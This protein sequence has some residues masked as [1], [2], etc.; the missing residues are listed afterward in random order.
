MSFRGPAE[1]S[2]VQHLFRNY[3]EKHYTNPFIPT[4]FDR[5]EF[6]YMLFGQKIMVRHL[7]FKSFEELKKT[8]AKEG[9][10]HVYRSAAIYQ[11]PQ[12]PMEEKGW[13]GAELIFDI[14]ADHLK[15]SCK[16]VHDYYLCVGCG[17][18]LGSK[19][20]K[21]PKCG[22]EDA[23]EIKMVCDECL[24]KTKKEMEKLVDFLVMD[25][26][27]ET[28]AM[29][30]SFSGNRGYHLA[31]CSEQVMELDRAS[32][33]E[34]VEYIT[35]A[36]VELR[37]HG[38]SLISGDKSGP[39]FQD[40]GWGGR[41]ARGCRS[42]LD[43]LSAGGEEVRKELSMHL[44]PKDLSNMAEL[45]RYWRDSPRW[46][47]LKTGRRSPYLETLARLAIEDSASHIDTVVTTDVHRLLRLSDTLNGKTGLKACTV[48]LDDF[49]SFNPLNDSVVF[50]SEQCVEVRVLPT[51]AF[52]IGD[53]RYGPYNNEVVKLPVYVAVYLLC[54]GLAMM[55][56][57]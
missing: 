18:V 21:C 57:R 28:S 55:V 48:K 31:V 34:I 43:R 9:P 45:A 44:K 38:L 8:L 12:A 2:F 40:A 6:G 26:G 14:D 29:V 53:E 24:S 23:A 13:T 51:P 47:L 42:L 17:S 1:A 56:K 33:L 50:D 10:L 20:G 37:R 36:H 25:F 3:Y 15:T 27:I 54:R 19:T 52:Q 46:D 30:L 16:Q 22:N 35:G 4:H 5:R 39:G 7:A 41:I 11:Y 32:R 49:H